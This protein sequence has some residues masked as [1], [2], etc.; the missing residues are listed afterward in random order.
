[1]MPGNDK[2]D[3][4]NAGGQQ[5]NPRFD[6]LL[7]R[8]S[9]AASVTVALV[10]SLGL[11]GWALDIPA[12]KSV[13]PDWVT[14]KANTALGLVLAG[15][16]L[17]ILGNQQ[18]RARLRRLA[19][20]AAGVVALIGVL[21]LGE[22]TLGWDLGIDQL[23]FQEPD[24]AVGTVAP[25]R[26][27]PTTACSFLL[28]GGGLLLLNRSRTIHV[29]QWCALTAGGIG[30][31]NLLSYAYS[32]P[33]F[34]G[35]P[36]ATEMAVH[37]AAASF[38]LSLGLL[39]ARPERGVMAPLT[40]P[41]VGGVMAR[42]LLIPATGGLLLLGW[43][44]VLGE[45]AGLYDMALGTALL[46]L[47]SVILVALL[48][49][50]NARLLNRVD[51]ERRR[52]QAD[53][54]KAYIEV[55]NQ[56]EERTA[57]LRLQTV[58]LTSAANAIVITD[59]NGRI[60]WLNPAFTRLTGYT[61]EEALGQTPRLL[62]SGKQDRAFHQRL[63]ETILAGQVWQSELVN[64]R[65][66]GTLYTEEQTITPVR[67]ERG[68]ISHFIAIHQDLTERKRAEK[69]QRLLNEEA[70][71]REREAESFA[72]LVTSL[73]RSLELDEILERV[74]AEA[75]A[76]G[77]GDIAYLV[78]VG[79]GGQTAAIRA[80][81]GVSSALRGLTIPKGKGIA[82]Q[83][84]ETGELFVTDDYFQDSRFPHTE[85]MDAVA[86]AEG[87]VALA[88]VPIVHEGT[89]LGVLLVARRASRPFTLA[90]L[91]VVIRLAEAASLACHHALL[92]E[93]AARRAATLERLWRVG[94]GLSRP[95]ALAETLDRIVETARDLLR[96][97]SAQLAQRGAAADLVTVTAE[98]G[99]LALLRHR[100]VRLG[101]G[102]IGTVA[103]T[104]QPLVLNDYQAFP[105]RLPELTMVSAAMAVPLLVED[106][107]V[108]ILNVDSTEQGRAFSQ[109][110]L[111]LLELLAQP[112]A[113]ALENARLYEALKQE[114]Y[115]LE[116]RVEERTQELQV[117]MR[118]V[119]E[120]SRY[121]SDFLANMSHELRTPLNSIIGFSDL[122][123]AQSYGTLNEKQSRHAKNI[124]TSGRHL[125]TLIN[126][127][128]D[129]SKVEAGR[130]E[131]DPET[132]SL[133]ETLQAVLTDIRPQAESKGVQLRL[134]SEGSLNLLTADPVRF[135]QILYNLLSNAV[136]FTPA[137]GD[138]TLAAR[139]VENTSVE[140]AVTDTGIG[141]KTEDLPRLFQPFTQLE[142]ALSGRYQGTGLGLALTKRLVEL[143]GGQIRAESEGEGKGTTLTVRLP[144]GAPGHPRD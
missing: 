142:A 95:L 125:L 27:A 118:R 45:K 87:I 76:L 124:L 84:L 107:L 69:Q 106:R 29:G 28:L 136:K 138:V 131:L 53:L 109:D 7:R 14:M 121:K 41:E 119:E 22:Y 103:A 114:A 82:G 35:F 71:R 117:A 36:S 34:Y 74:V 137:G 61:P 128:L 26:M 60:A 129:L 134:E 88:A 111:Q 141:I 67:D 108:G 23:L 104:R 64:R 37:T 143:H 65:K 126:D 17:G 98:A 99:D 32:V 133:P 19:S 81:T 73:A 31:A 110:D 54:D 123:L 102:S 4:E 48:V 97:A 1:M 6:L 75:N 21:T 139:P 85:E 68:E 127:I 16:S 10:G 115:Q 2:R 94:Q 120:A 11:V 96:V 101:E 113:I 9:Q 50:W 79:G 80:H 78:M 30:L 112:A 144:L 70:V 47:V 122:L 83:V 56:V 40:S 105:N 33:A 58:A 100:T 72:G 18:A 25:G 91:Q 90:N 43:L 3:R 52:A 55:E 57:Q 44:K 86:R 59:R 5:A 132:F 46:V 89:P 8:V 77:Q 49:G 38:L 20:A 140:I 116:A 93:Q 42:R 39:C 15:A 63:W 135:K 62:N 51:A 92:Y 130:L 24:G 12:L 13:S 66:D